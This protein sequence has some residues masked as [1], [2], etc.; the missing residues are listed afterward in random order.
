MSMRCTYGIF[1]ARFFLARLRCGPEP[2]DTKERAKQRL[3]FSGVAA[4]S[5]VHYHTSAIADHRTSSLVC[6]RASELA[7]Q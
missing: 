3:D 7:R 2:D 5:L 4:T 6:Q 1:R